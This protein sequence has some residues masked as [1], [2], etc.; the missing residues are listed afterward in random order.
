MY[1][2]SK[3]IFI[4][5]SEIEGMNFIGN[6]ETGLWVIGQTVDA[7]IVDEISKPFKKKVCFEGVGKIVLNMGRQCNLNCTYCLVGGLKTQ[8]F[9][10]SEEVG[11]ATINRI[12][13]LDQT[14]KHVVFHG[15]EPMMNYRLIKKLLIY[16]SNN[17]NGKI[18]FSIQSNGTL[19]NKHNLKL[20]VQNNVGIGI[21]IDGHIKHHNK[22]RPYKNGK[23]SFDDVFQ[24]LLNVK[25]YQGDISV[26]TVITK[27]NISDLHDVMKFY[28]DA[29]IKS[30]LFTPVSPIDDISITPD[31][32]ELTLNM[33]KLISLYIVELEKGKETVKIRNLRDYLRLFFRE[34][35]TSNCLQCGGGPRQPILAIDYDGSIYPCDYFWGSEY[36]KIGN[37]FDMD[38]ETS[39][40]SKKNLRNV[41]SIN[42]FRECCKCNWKR[43]CGGGC[44]GA[45]ATLTGDI[46][47]KSFY[48]DYNKSMLAFIAGL[49]PKLHHLGLIGKI[50]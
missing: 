21:S 14:D 37:V 1:S 34:K 45:T 48:C 6:R 28:D 38:F 36:F 2:I 13:E 16:N 10:L 50:I 30:V 42:D 18:T 20:L 25:R 26:I 3:D 23:D 17:Y 15:S 27:H 11:Y 5:P 40:Q 31:I 35:T 22:T 24:G 44:M 8:P 33:Q 19:F 49:I 9:N 41:R 43:F 39:L 7:Y 47:G 29:G 4:I 46:I 12:S 32:D